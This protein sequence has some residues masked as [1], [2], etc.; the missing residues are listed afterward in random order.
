MLD[1][2]VGI[3]HIYIC[4]IDSKRLEHGRRMICA[5]SASFCALRLEDGHVPT[6]WPLL[7]LL[8]RALSLLN[9]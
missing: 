3:G 1:I 5:G 4:R 2:G 9:A 8:R 6:F 7:Y